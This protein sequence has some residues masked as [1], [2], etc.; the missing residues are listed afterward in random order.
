MNNKPKLISLDA[1][2]LFILTLAT[3]DQVPDNLSTWGGT[4]HWINAI[5]PF[6]P[7]L[8]VLGDP[9]KPLY[10]VIKVSMLMAYLFIDLLSIS[11]KRQRVL[12]AAKLIII[13]FI[14]SLTV[15]APAINWIASRHYAGP[16]TYAH[17][18][19]VVQTEEAVKFLLK[20]ENPYSVTYEK[21]PVMGSVNP[22][23]WE[24]HGVKENPIIHH[25]P[26]PPMTFVSAL[27]FLALSE[28]FIG[29]YDQRFV[30]LALFIAT[31]LLIYKI[32]EEP[33]AKL[34]IIIAVSLNPFFV[35]GVRE[36]MNDIL[37][38]FWVTLMLFFLQRGKTVLASLA[39]SLACGSKQ[40]AWVMVPFFFV[41]LYCWNS[42][43]G[44][45]DIWKFFSSRE[46]IAF[47][48]AAI[49]VF[50]PFLIWDAHAFIEDLLSFHAG[51]TQHPY[52]LRGETGYGFANLIL[53]L[54]MVKSTASY[55]PF[56]IFQILF[57]LPLLGVS[58]YQQ[59]RENSLNRMLVGY[60]VTLFVFLFFGRY[61]AA[62]YIGFVV[63]MLTVSFFI[64][65]RR[66]Q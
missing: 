44:K 5:L 16:S 33:S 40:M 53:H 63:S 11:E 66:N 21:T 55:F 20:G 59:T 56:T 49:V 42:S 3:M 27:P 7:E 43:S 64:K 54:G 6:K 35:S 4:V 25:F 62:N 29:W 41:Y 13:S 34:S 36:G 26:Y 47:I 10:N 28:A 8:M 39:L 45:T 58:L 51:T 57:T 37:L 48:A 1:L 9:L 38:L 23:I 65:E 2:L 46:V 22:V 18:G 12:I 52:P 17:D 60:T 19:G 14:V 61:F 30:Y 15:I 50:L 24:R 32:P 31:L